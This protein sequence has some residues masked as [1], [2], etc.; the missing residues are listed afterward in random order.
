MSKLVYCA[1]A[2]GDWNKALPVGGGRI[3][4]MIFGGEVEE[5]YQI[6]EDSVWFGSYRNRNNDDAKSH[7]SE[8]RS[9]ILAGEINKAEKLLKYTFSG[10]PQ[11]MHP[12]QTMGDVYIDLS[13][14]IKEVINYKRE[15]DLTEAIHYVTSEDQV[16]GIILKR[17]TFVSATHN[18]IVSRFTSNQKGRITTGI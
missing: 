14:T 9:L 7:L 12:Y 16:T 3:G 5:H 11:S 1:S 18:C 2:G 6:N 13:D 4:A 17:E 10:T 15:L 8:V